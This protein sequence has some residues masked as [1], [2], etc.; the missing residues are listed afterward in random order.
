MARRSKKDTSQQLPLTATVDS[1]PP[2]VKGPDQETESLTSDPESGSRPTALS[3]RDDAASSRTVVPP[4]PLPDI[5]RPNVQQAATTSPVVQSTPTQAPE[6]RQE[7][8]IPLSGFVWLY[9]EEVQVVDHP[10]FQRLGRIY[11]LGQ[12]HLLHR[13]ATHKRMEHALGALHMVQRMIGAIDHT[14]KDAKERSGGLKYACGVPLRTHEKR[15]VRLGALLHDIG[16]VAAGHTVEDELCLIGKHDEDTRLD[17]LFTDS[18]W[19]DVKN[20]TLG[21]LIDLEF[22]RHVPRELLDSSVT[23]SDIV[24]LLIR[25]RPHSEDRY[26]HKQKLLGSSDALRF[27]ICRDMIGNTICADLLDYLHRDWYH[28]GKPRP[29]DER[30]LQYMEIRP[31]KSEHNLNLDPKPAASDQFVISLGKPSNPRTDAVSSILEL[32]EWRYQLA[33]SVLFHRTKLAAAAMLDRALYELWRGRSQDLERFLLPLSDEQMLFECRREQEKL[34]DGKSATQGDRKRREISSKLLEALEKRQLFTTLCSFTYHELRDR[35]RADVQRL[36][37]KKPQAGPNICPENRSRVLRQLEHDFT[38]TPGSLAMY[39]PTED[40]NKKIAEVKIAVGNDISP[41][42]EYER[43]HQ[44]QQLAGGHLQAQLNRFERLWSVHFFIDRQE[45]DKRGEALVRLL[46]KAVKQLAL[47]DLSDTEDLKYEAQE[48]ARALLAI[49]KSRWIGYQVVE[50]SVA[51]SYQDASHTFG[52]Y[53]TGAPSI[54]SYL[55]QS[56]D[57]QA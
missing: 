48:L 6:R 27:G 54:F 18:A 49:E 8:F 5:K 57:P 42:D 7:F 1:I 39:C 46:R 11:Q 13:G 44:G 56:D 36:Y 32:L 15:F 16:H 50:H 24:R 41:F 30:I 2:T 34:R 12:V 31:T 3:G 17:L 25:K 52:S 4:T 38:L 29:F 40:M 55:Q 23:A 19:S 45:K 9:P 37:S 28:I 47:G 53:P 20:R 33:E 10:A 43:T 51:A 22:N 21:A 26:Q 14:S 35:V